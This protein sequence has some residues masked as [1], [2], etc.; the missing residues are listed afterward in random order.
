MNKTGLQTIHLGD[1]YTEPVKIQPDNAIGILYKNS[2]YAKINALQTG[3]PS[4]LRVDLKNMESWLLN[5]TR[6]FITPTLQMRFYYTT[7]LQYMHTVTKSNRR[8]TRFNGCI[9]HT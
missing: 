7:P 8:C 5:T 6:D 1:F 4:I 3:P 9:K 2:S